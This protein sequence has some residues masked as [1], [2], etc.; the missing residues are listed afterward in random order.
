MSVNLHSQQPRALG[1]RHLSQ[2][3]AMW[4]MDQRT[5][6]L[7]LAG[8]GLLRI[9]HSTEK[10]LLQPPLLRISLFCSKGTDCAP[11]VGHGSQ[12]LP[13]PPQKVSAGRVATVEQRERGRGPPP[14]RALPLPPPSLP[15]GAGETP[16]WPL[17]EAPHGP[18]ALRATAASSAWDLAAAGQATAWGGARHSPL[19]PA[20][21]R[22]ASPRAL[23]AGGRAAAAARAPSPAPGLARPRP[24]PPW[25]Q[26]ASISPAPVST[27]RRREAGASSPRRPELAR[28]GPSAR[29]RRWVRPG[30]R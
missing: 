28:P 1:N 6:R 8:N 13:V 26:G 7:S 21:T 20:A 17:T 10:Q 18:A 5:Q 9:S 29:K 15:L 4:H 12:G 22:Q 24:R 19:V 3:G 2:V 25:R 16:T 14:P 23:G 30:R 11:C 27:E